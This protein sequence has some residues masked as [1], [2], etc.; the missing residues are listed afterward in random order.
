MIKFV[1]RSVAVLG[2][3]LHETMMAWTTQTRAEPKAW[4]TPSLSTS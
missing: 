1:L 4:N 3:G 2:N